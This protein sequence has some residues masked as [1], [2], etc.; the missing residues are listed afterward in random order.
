MECKIFTCTV[1]ILIVSTTLS[2]IT[3]DKAVMVKMHELQRD[4][5]PFALW[6]RAHRTKR[7]K[8]SCR[9][10]HFTTFTSVL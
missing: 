10:G 9:K 1:D 7:N 8:L 6:T 2:I 3:L 4:N 5:D